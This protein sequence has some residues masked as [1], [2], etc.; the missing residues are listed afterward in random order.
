MSRL[1]IPVGS[2]DHLIGP[3]TA[4][5]TFVEYGDF[6]CPY[7]GAAYWEVN[8][9]LA[10]M[11]DQLRYVFRHFPLTEAHPFAMQAAEAAEAADAQGR[12]WEMHRLLYENQ[13]ALDAESLL[14]YARTLD[15]DMGRFARDLSEHRFLERIRRDFMG[16]VRSGVSGTPGFFI[17]GRGYLGDFSAPALLSVLQGG[18]VGVPDYS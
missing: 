17:N 14:A 5:L 12:F 7:C 13:E 18:D 16:G 4:R 11:G 6:E 8:K 9:V 1:R 3:P 15:L 2:Q 10:A